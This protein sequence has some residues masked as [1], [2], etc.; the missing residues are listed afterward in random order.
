MIIKYFVPLLFFL[1]TH[2]AI[3]QTWQEAKR[4]QK[5]ILEILW[6]ES[7]PFI[8]QNANGEMEGLEVDILRAFSDYLEEIHNVK[9]SMNWVK[10]GGFY[11]IIKMTHTSQSPNIL[12]ASAFSI[13]EERK[14]LIK[15]STSYLP[16][17]TVLVSSQGTPIVTNFEQ[18]ESLMQG[19]T[20]IT[21]SGTVYESLLLDLQDK[22][23]MNFEIE[24]ISS[25]DNVLDYIN[26]T[27]KSFGFI[28]LPIY[29]MWIKK[30]SPLV[31]QNFFTAQG[32]GYGFIMPKTSDWNVPLRQF[33]NSPTYR[34]RIGEIISKHIGT[35]IF[36]FIDNLNEG[37]ILGTTLLTKEKEMHQAIIKNVTARLAKEESYRHYLLIVISLTLVFILAISLGLYKIGKNNRL[38]TRQKSQIE[39]Q[40]NDIRQK[41]DQLLNRNEKLVKVN[42]EK[43]YLVNILA[44]DLR[45]P[46]TNIM[47]LTEILGSNEELSHE[48]RRKFFQTIKNSANRMNQMITKIL[49]KAVEDRQ[50]ESLKIEEVSTLRLMQEL[51]NRFKS[52][53]TEKSIDLDCR[54]PHEDILLQT[55]HLLVTL[56]LENLVSNALKFS[57]PNTTVLLDVDSNNNH[58]I[59]R[60]KDQ[61]PGFS[62]EDKLLLFNKL[63][64][65]SAKPTGGEPSTGLGLSIA[66]K[67]VTDLGGS[68]KLE[69]QLGEGSTFFVS[70]PRVHFV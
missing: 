55:D 43:N 49:T 7:K 58:V 36:E 3:S 14:E 52:V 20:A 25:D 8:R 50:N 19:M 23:N 9:L 18:I 16:D 17:I 47:G 44:H 69:S 6:Y 56:I 15:Y 35:D 21:I 48:E 37:E 11:D 29:L 1:F 63:Q 57:P 33:M 38:L 54:I 13:T 70:L 34:D 45:S 62:N 22:L 4:S 32:T 46:L 67:Y 12:G 27:P 5:A 28:D 40:Q 51:E 65:L 26:Q 68:I 10:P 66:K 41:N 60:V 39:A 31:R 61:G 64:P 24:Y 53:A 30:G 59:F 2:N 42:D